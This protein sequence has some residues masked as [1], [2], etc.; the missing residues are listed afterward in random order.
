VVAAND[1]GGHGFE[2]WTSWETG[3]MWLKGF[4]PYD[5]KGIRMLSYGYNSSQDEQ[6]VEI[7]FLDHRRHLLQ[8]LANARHSTPVRILLHL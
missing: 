8:T 2:S 1:L 4:L 5:I 3:K 6:T 7:D